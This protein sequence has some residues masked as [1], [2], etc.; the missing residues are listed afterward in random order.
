MATTFGQLQE[1]NPDS[2]SFSGYVERVNIFFTVNDIA[3]GREQQC[4]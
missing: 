4:S 1:F 2:D 3:E